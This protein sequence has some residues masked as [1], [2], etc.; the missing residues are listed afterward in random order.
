MRSAPQEPD[1]GDATAADAAE[2][3]TTGESKRS[4]QRAHHVQHILGACFGAL[5]LG[6]VVA[7]VLGIWLNSPGGPV[8]IPDPDALVR[9]GCAAPLT[10]DDPTDYV[11][12]RCDD[13]K[14]TVLILDI[15]GPVDP[16]GRPSCPFGTDHMIEL[17]SPPITEPLPEDDDEEPEE[18]EVDRILCARDLL[19][20]HPG[21]PGAGGGQIVAGDCIH[22]TDDEEIVEV[23]CDG[24]GDYSADLKILAI[25]KKP[26]D[27]P[28]GTVEGQEATANV[29]PLWTELEPGAPGY[30]GVCTRPH[31][32][33]L[34]E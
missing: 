20:P 27:C 8:V 1:K 16:P 15:V 10:D 12:V 26:D 24:S 33:G 13:P 23:P 34:Q 22:V 31:R 3:A 18:P 30:E 7:T 6:M 21:D 19:P 29:Y 28:D 9:A 32:E 25:V 2:E 11:G 17:Y 4:R 14:A 5:A